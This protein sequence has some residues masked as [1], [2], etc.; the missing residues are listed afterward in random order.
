M[1]DGVDQLTENMSD[2][3]GAVG[4]TLRV[5]SHADKGTRVFGT[6]PIAR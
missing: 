6:V 2:R 1:D 5:E 4:G 3:I